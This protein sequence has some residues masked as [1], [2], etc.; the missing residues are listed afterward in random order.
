MSSGT[1]K[2]QFP[3]LGLRVRTC[4]GQKPRVVPAVPKGCVTTLYLEL[5]NA[6][7]LSRRNG[8]AT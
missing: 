1:S 5:L 6:Q 2:G 3:A 7:K 4:T 8:E